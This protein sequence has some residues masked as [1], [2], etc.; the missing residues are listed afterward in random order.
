M[1]VGLSAGI[2]VRK[3]AARMYEYNSYVG[4]R[5]AGVDTGQCFH[6]F[7][8]SQNRDPA[9]VIATMYFFGIYFV[10]SSE[11]MHARTRNSSASTNSMSNTVL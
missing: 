3:H 5:P 4:C 11:N 6:V 9:T 2:Y 8:G 1:F 10:F 7:L